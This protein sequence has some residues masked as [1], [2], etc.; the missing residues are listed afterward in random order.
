LF[1]ILFNYIDESTTP[2]GSPPADLQRTFGLHPAAPAAPAAATVTSAPSILQALAN[3]ARQNT[4]APSTTSA[5]PQ[6][7]SY[8]VSNAHNNAAQQAPALNQTISFP[9][10]SQPVNVPA[11]FQPQ[12]SSNGAQNFVSNQTNPNPYAVVPPVVPPAAL[13]P[14]LQQQLL[15]VKALA[16]QGLTPEQIQGVLARMGQGLPML[17]AGGL[18]PP[19]QFAAQ[20]QPQNQNQN[21]QNGWGSNGAS[22]PDAPRDRNGYHD[23]EAVRSP[24][25]RYRQRSRSRSPPRGWNARDSPASRRHDEPNNYD[26]D[27]NSPARNRGD[28]RGRG[29]RGGRGND[30]RQRSPPR[31]G[32]SPTPPRS[33]GAGQKWIDH[34]P[35]ISKGSIK[36]RTRIYACS[37]SEF[38]TDKL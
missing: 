3:L 37:S 35:T 24:P 11:T 30:Y 33:R 32:R 36:G 23:R 20:Q 17:G 22:R 38:I 10:V 12:G 8:N 13:D 2:P 16:D 25:N 21:V 26:F 34:D 15:F 6:D 1:L 18:P 19:P 27:R 9:P 31:R 4:T 14:A 28:E 7:N 5:Q 29:G